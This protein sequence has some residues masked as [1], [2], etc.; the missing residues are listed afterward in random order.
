M[1]L[2]EERESDA[3]LIRIY[4]IDYYYIPELNMNVY[5]GG[6]PKEGYI[7]RVHKA[8]CTYD[9]SCG[10]YTMFSTDK[11]GPV[12]S[13]SDLG[14]VVCEYKEMFIFSLGIKALVDRINADG[15]SI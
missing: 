8:M 14:E 13:R 9:E 3:G 6:E 4:S 1:K 5:T 2:V 11:G 12:I 15:G 7:K 10:L